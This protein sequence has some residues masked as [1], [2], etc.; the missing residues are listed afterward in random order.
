[1]C[2]RQIKYTLCPYIWSTC[3][4]SETITPILTAT[5]VGILRWNLSKKEED[6][7]NGGRARRFGGYMWP[8]C[9][10]DS[11]VLHQSPWKWSPAPQSD[12]PELERPLQPLLGQSP[13][14][15]RSPFPRWYKGGWLATFSRG[16]S[17]EWMSSWA[18]KCFYCPSPRVLLPC[19]GFPYLAF[20][21]FMT[22]PL[23]KLFI[24]SLS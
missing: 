14:W 7:K 2:P 16:Y 23:S 24:H 5:K 6:S 18:R 22:F 21:T 15:S 12:R 9:T 8:L 1:M 19:Y 17:E 20:G 11:I 4:P 3:C 13:W 10:W